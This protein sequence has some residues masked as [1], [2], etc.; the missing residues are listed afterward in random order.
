MN[1]S[2]IAQKELNHVDNDAKRLSKD[3]LTYGIAVIIPALIGIISI[4]IYTRIFSV[5]AYG[6][7]NQVFNTTLVITTLFSQ[8]IQQSI[9]RYRPLY[10][11][12]S[13]L[14]QFD[15]NLMNL[16]AL[17]FLIIVGFGLV[18]GIFKE[19]L[20][21][22]ESYYWICILLVLTQ[23]TFLVLGAL[24]QSDF[25]GKMYKNYNLLTAILKFVFGLLLIFYVNRAP[26]SIVYGLVL[27]Q[28]ILLISMFRTTG[29]SIRLIK[30]SRLGESLT[31]IKMF[32]TYG[33][34]MVGWFIGTSIL[35]LADRY[36]L[37]SLGT[38]K[39]VGVYSANYSI[40]SA[41]LGLL[42]TPLLTAA[43]PIIMNK[44]G[45]LPDIEIG[46][47]ITYFTR[48]Y[49]TISL[50]LLAFIAV[51][52]K[53]ITQLF[54]GESFREGS[55]IIPILFLGLIFWNVGMYGHKGYEIREKTKVMLSFIVVSALVN[56][57]LNLF[58]I[59]SYGYIGAAIATLISMGIYPLLIKVFSYKYITWRINLLSILKVVLITIITALVVG[60][61]KNFLSNYIFFQLVFGG[62]IGLII[63]ISL[64]FVL[65]EIDYQA[66]KKK[67]TAKFA[68]R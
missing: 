7:Y 11:D 55:I 10:R 20:G 67:V 43:H 36:M 34:P 8:W 63:Y 52:H 57:I 12:K 3:T 18:G 35:N 60:S 2:N 64:L 61:L 45:K 41:S 58:L 54:L 21:R 23:F 53:E 59:P 37:E 42:T 13:Q 4:S 15:S 25:K 51:F 26:V 16:L 50:P 9:Q 22:Y 24:L 44:V 62:G 27:G 65:K 19:L 1:N 30:I 66:I 33:F 29:L 56:I 17:M 32:V 49:L 39:D 68:K 6:E 5:E 47:T 48:I 40:V 14:K 31:F 46:K 38:I 28:L